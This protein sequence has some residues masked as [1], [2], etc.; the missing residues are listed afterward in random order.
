MSERSSRVRHDAS[1]RK[2]LIVDV[3]R[4]AEDEAKG[5]LSPKGRRFETFEERAG[6][7]C[8]LFV[9]SIFSLHIIALQNK[10]SE[11]N[12]GDSVRSRLGRQCTNCAALSL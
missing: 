8:I 6:L 12:T 5:V 4:N 9:F 7:A 2:N 11:I 1:D 10:D 3:S